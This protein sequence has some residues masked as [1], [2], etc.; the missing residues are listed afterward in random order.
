[1]VTLA[2]EFSRS[3]VHVSLVL[4]T[5]EG[6]YLSLVP[7]DIEIV[8][9]KCRR[10]LSALPRLVGYLRRARPSGV[11]SAMTHA[12]LTALWA[13]RIAGV[14]T[15]I[16]VSERN[17]LSR[18]SRSAPAIKMKLMPYLARGY[19]PW[20]DDIVA[21]SHGVADDLAEVAS[22]PKGRIT[23][24]Y[25]PIVSDSLTAR[26]QQPLDH[27]WFEAGRDPVVLAV[28]RLTPQK[29]FATLIHAFA[30]ARTVR[31]SNLVILGEGLERIRLQRLAGGL[32]L[33]DCVSMP[34]FVQNPLSYMS[35]AAVVVLSSAW[36]GFPAVLVEAMA[37]GTPVVSTNCPNGPAE[38][39]EHGRYG[40]LVPVG[41]IDAL[42]AGIANT[43]ESRPDSN[44][45]KHRANAFRVRDG[46]DA[47][48]QLLLGSRRRSTREASCNTAAG[49]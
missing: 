15:R 13:R 38:I 21:V 7:P 10:V 45:M 32:G 48:L 31:R 4:A 12:N 6:P 49:E 9:L 18:T 22:L 35:R 3:G 26:A 24:I 23:V 29:D 5:A 47:Y 8:D 28:G 44:L 16:V 19:Y 25:N 11:L 39:L 17:T 27:S 36:E 30:R 41:D 46:V 34:G 42:A 37:C 2:T 43:L 33:R 14:S 1:M 20:A 40:P